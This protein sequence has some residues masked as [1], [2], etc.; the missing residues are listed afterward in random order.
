MVAYTGI[1]GTLSVGGSEIA[2]AEFS[3]KISRGVA[4]HPRAGKYSDL[5]RSGK[6]DIT[7]TIK[8]IQSDAVMLGRLLNTTALTGTA[9]TMHAGLTLDGSDTTYAI[10][11]TDAQDSRVRLTVTDYA[12]TTAGTVTLIG[13][14]INGNNQTE[15]IAITTLAATSYVTSGKVWGTITHA[16]V[17]DVN[18]TSGGVLAVASL[19]GSTN[20]A[21][22]VSSVFDIIGVVEDSD[23]NS[24]TI[25]ASNCFLTDGEL[26]ISDADTI[27]SEP[28]SW[29]MQDP[30]SD[31]KID[32]VLV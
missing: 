13:T 20:Y 8:R 22:G 21:V 2:F 14:D 19:A 4:S 32:G 24:I 18:S 9:G 6:L 23:G 1:H 17:V 29:T 30:D 12:V 10:T 11:T 31:F 7:G 16:T 5:K 28:V 26:V 27:L 3:V 25:T 15:T